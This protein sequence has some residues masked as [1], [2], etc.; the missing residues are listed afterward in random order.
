MGELRALGVHT[1]V[2]GD[3]TLRST[4]TQRSSIP[5]FRPALTFDSNHLAILLDRFSTVLSKM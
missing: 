4:T 1:G 5:R 3:L 2:C